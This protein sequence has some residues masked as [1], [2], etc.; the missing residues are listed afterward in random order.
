MLHRPGDF[1][2]GNLQRLC[3]DRPDRII[4][5]NLHK[6]PRQTHDGCA[7]RFLQRGPYVPRDAMLEASARKRQT[8]GNVNEIQ[9]GNCRSCIHAAAVQP[10]VHRRS[11]T[12]GSGLES[13]GIPVVLKICFLP[14]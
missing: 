12:G 6:R 2:C 8:V 14:L 3:D 13:Y 4:R 5:E 11:S 10:I 9:G 7:R 1:A